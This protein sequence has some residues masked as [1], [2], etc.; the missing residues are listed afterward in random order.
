MAKG[1]TTIRKISDWLHLWLGIVVGIF[2]IIISLTGA[3]Y[4]FERDIRDVTE[5]YRFVEQQQKPYLPP[6]VLKAAAE[7][8]ACVKV[9][10]IQYGV[11]GE[12]VAVT[13]TKKP[14]GF[15]YL[16]MNP[17]TGAV[18]K[19]KILNKDFF[20]II[21]AGHFYLWLPPAI[22]KPIVNTAVFIFIFL[23]ISGLIM[24]WPKRWNKANRQKSF[25]INLKAS[26]K[27]VN[28]DLHNVLGFYVLLVAFIIAVTGLVYGYEWYRKTYHYTITGGKSL[29]ASKRPVSD[30]ISVRDTTGMPVIDRVFASAY[31]D[32]QPITG[33]LQ[34]SVPQ[35]N[36]DAIAVTY[37]PERKTYYKREFR[38]FDRYNAK[39]ITKAQ[40]EKSLGEKIYA[41]NYDIHVG[42]ILGWP[43][44]ILAF[45]AAMICASLPVTGFMIWRGRRKKAKKKV[46]ED[47]QLIVEEYLEKKRSLR[48]I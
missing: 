18:I 21:L 34:F 30:T 27:R 32:Y 3:I 28:Y 2:V 36:A 7:K 9:S 46:L 24:W 11:P 8:Y 35:R 39:E 25:R 47:K 43:G 14:Q 45:A 42:A 33:M 22:G 6:S 10:G 38:Y 26:F 4:V 31:R 12:A 1:K 23:L 48:A 5:T 37:N 19:E 20:R 15:T 44:K 16:Y 17:Y 29:V 40:A 41:A 13:Y